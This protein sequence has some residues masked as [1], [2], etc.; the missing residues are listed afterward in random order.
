M[1]YEIWMKSSAFNVYGMY[2]VATL[3]W[4]K[5][6]ERVNSLDEIKWPK[7]LDRCQYPIVYYRY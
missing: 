3:N 6:F 1:F 5:N 7:K 4:V 2:R